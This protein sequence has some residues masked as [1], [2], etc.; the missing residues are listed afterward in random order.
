MRRGGNRVPAILI[1]GTLAVT[2]GILWALVAVSSARLV[3][4]HVH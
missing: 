2:Q 1:S 3:T 4:E